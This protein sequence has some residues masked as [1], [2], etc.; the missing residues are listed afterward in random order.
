[1]KPVDLRELIDQIHV[2]LDIEWTYD[3]AVPA[4][5]SLPMR[6]LLVMD[7]PGPGDIDELM[8]LS[9]IG[10]VRGIEAKLDELVAQSA[11]YQPLVGQLR[12]L[13]SSFDLRGF[14]ATLAAIR[15]IHV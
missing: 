10:Y 1:M 8:R 9:E 6:E 13:A 15:R 4:L 7:A 3:T 5:S 14:N 11:R 2:L 12:V